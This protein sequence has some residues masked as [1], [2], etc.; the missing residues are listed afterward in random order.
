MSCASCVIDGYYKAK[1]NCRDGKRQG[2]LVEQPRIVDGL[3]AVA[4]ER[5]DGEASRQQ[6]EAEDRARAEK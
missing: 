3:V 5:K 2:L 1:T 4:A 6:V